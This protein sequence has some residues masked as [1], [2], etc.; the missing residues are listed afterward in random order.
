MGHAGRG[1]TRGNLTLVRGVP[2]PV[3]PVGVSGRAERVALT[4]FRR[5]DAIS[6]VKTMRKVPIYFSTGRY[7]ASAFP[8][9]GI[10]PRRITFVRRFRGRRKVT[11]LLVSFARERRFCCLHFS[12]LRGF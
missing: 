11:F 5:G 6:C 2:A 8:L 9:T 3:A 10:R 4:C 7:G 1:C 12:S